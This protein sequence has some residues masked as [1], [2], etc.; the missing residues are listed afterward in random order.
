M[1]YPFS[2][3]P[4]IRTEF[5]APLSGDVT[6]NVEPRVFSPD[7]AGDPRIESRIHRN[8]ASY[9]TQLG[10]ILEALETL[11]AATDT[12]LPQIDSLVERVEAEKTHHRETLRREAEEALM[13]LKRA[14]ETAWTEVIQK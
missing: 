14:D 1:S 8:I 4:T 7:I 13:R 10:K 3:F 11:S 9:G 2:L 12:P 6:Q 5:H